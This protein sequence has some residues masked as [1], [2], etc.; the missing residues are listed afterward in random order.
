MRENTD[1]DSVKKI[2]ISF[3][4]IPIEQTKF[5]PAIISH[6]IFSCG[7]V[8]SSTKKD[9]VDITASE[10]NFTAMCKEVSD[11]IRQASN[12]TS[13]LYI[14]RKQY[15]LA[16]L[17]HTKKYLSDE[18]FARTL[19]DSWVVS[20]NPNQDVNVNT[21]LAAKWF[22]EADKKY[23]M[24]EQEYDVYSSLPQNIIVYRGVGV[25]G[26]KWGLSW[27]SNYKKAEW[28]AG[29]F[30]EGNRRGYILKADADKKDILA[31]FNSRN[32]DELVINPKKLKNVMKIKCNV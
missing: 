16:F 29:R 32:E 18:D 28:F 5:S 31:Y 24:D 26:K 20:E 30:N 14:I 17:K 7:L 2:A 8:Y 13:I 23:L 6:P 19:A 9:V 3:L 1:L 25:G 22:A 15:R 27:T 12:L 11:T 10:E 4:Y 21:A